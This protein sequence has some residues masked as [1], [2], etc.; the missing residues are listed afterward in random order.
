M[1]DYWV[2]NDGDY[3]VLMN[4]SEIV[5]DGFECRADAWDYVAS[6]ADMNEDTF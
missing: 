1:P 5:A 4:G 6:L 3:F 2:K